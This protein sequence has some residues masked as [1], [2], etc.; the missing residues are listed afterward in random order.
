MMLT[1]GRE[2]KIFEIGNVKVGGK[3]GELPTVLIGSIFYDRHKIV[4][5]PAEGVFDRNR[6]EALINRQEEMS[7]RTGNPH[8]VDVV[9]SSETAIAKYIEFVAGVTDAPFFVDSTATEIKIAGLKYCAEVGL[10]DRT[11]YNSITF[12]VS[13]QEI[14]ELKNIGIKSAI[15]LGYNPRNVRPQGRIEL[16]KGD[17]NKKGLLQYAEEAGIKNILVDAAVLD[18]PSIGIASEAVRLIKAEL[19]LPSGGGPLNA[20]LEWKRVTELGEHAKRVCAATAVTSMV[21]AGA[22]W[23]LYGP[24]YNADVVFPAVA[25][26]D[27][28]IAYTNSRMRVISIQTKNHPLYKIF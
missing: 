24:I 9:A 1:F 10:L 8:M 18:V 16:L 17:E 21:Q 28:T 2:Q 13:D 12:H 7:D 6:A 4:S 3:P 25:M 19:G 23:V 22:D 11:V 15:L 14:E 20:V 5:D 27:S 26:V